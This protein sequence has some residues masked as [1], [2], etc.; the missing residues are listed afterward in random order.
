MFPYHVA[1]GGFRVPLA[2]LLDKRVVYALARVSML[3]DIR[4]AATSPA[5]SFKPYID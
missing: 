2:R 1:T 4:D 3:E 5:C